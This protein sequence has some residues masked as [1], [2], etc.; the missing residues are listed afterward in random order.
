M[1]HFSRYKTIAI[2]ASVLIAFIFALPN[3]VSPAWQAKMFSVVGA[4]PMTLGLDLQGGVNVVLELDQKDFKTK[5]LK[6]LAGDSR[7]ALREAKVGYKGITQTENAVSV[8]ISNLA[9][10]DKTKTELKKLQQ[11]LN[12]GLLSSGSAVNLYDVTNQDEQINISF[13]P[14]GFDAKI[15]VA[16]Q[17][18]LKIVENRLNGLGTSEPVIQQQGKDRIAVQIPGIKNSQQVIDILGRTAKL[19]FQLLC[20]EQPTGANQN[21]PQECE[22]FPL[23]DKPEQTLWVQTSSRATV[24]GADLTDSQPSF[25]QSNSAVVTFK[26]NQKGSTRF[27]KLT[28]EN[29]GK[30]FAIVLDEKVVSY[31]NINEPILGGSG[32]ISGNFTTEETASLA[33]VLRSGA[34]PAKLTIVE[35]RTV[36]PSLGS[37][38]IKAGLLASAIGLVGVL[39]FMLVVYHLFGVFANLALLANL[40]MLIA[41]MS[42]MG[43]TLTLPGIAGIVLTMGMAVDSNVLVYERIREEW[44]NGRTALNAIETGFKAALATIIDANLTTLI[45]AFVLFG[46]GSG[47]VRGFAVTL[48]IGIVTT[49]FT[50]YTLT[51]L[52]IAYWVKVARPKE[53]PL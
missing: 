52:I 53:V 45:A 40:L 34:L 8:R 49:V 20:Q 4:K 50:A 31:P 36:G 11:P 7:I 29:V 37:D 26:F 12:G 38:S 22:S 5:L 33:V 3:A 25:D 35:E 2:L 28:S 30:P 43:F 16:I 18:S 13:S 15:A 6:Q 17:Q 44:R 48:S 51:R 39:I 46:V 21:P 14:Q 47:P 1:L 19:T 24:D 9:D 10:V 23:K 32:Q 41:I 42:V 27:A